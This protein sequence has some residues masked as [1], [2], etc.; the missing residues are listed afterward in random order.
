MSKPSDPA[1]FIFDM[2]GQWDKMSGEAKGEGGAAGFRQMV[3]RAL[4]AANMPGK[5][6]LA[7]IGARLS[8]V[9]AS[10]FRIEG[11]LAELKAA[12][13]KGGAPATTPDD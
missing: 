11:A 6:D 3:D 9:E 7:D 4:S 12:I 2:L 1:A 10:L 13:P 8:R 5:A